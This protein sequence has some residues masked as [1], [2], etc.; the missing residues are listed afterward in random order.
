MKAT[1]AI[2]FF[3]IPFCSSAQKEI[4]FSEEVETVFRTTDSTQNFYLALVPMTAVKGL[5]VILP[6]FGGAPRDM[7]KETDLPSKATREGYLVII[8]YLAFQTNTSDS[9]SQSRLT[10][11]I[12]EV[13]KKYDVPPD[14]FVIG[15]H[16]IGGNSALLYAEN[17]LKPSNRKAVKPNLAFGVDPPLD[18]PV[19][20]C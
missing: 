18:R 2:L 16:S 9:I 8:P 4:I 19:E 15:G 14:N 5:L 7:L 3:I 6:G 10:T 17:A 13:I 12:I 20:E 11:L 1:I